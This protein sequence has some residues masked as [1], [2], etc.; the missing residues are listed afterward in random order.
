M[1]VAQDPRAEL[2]RAAPSGI[3]LFIDNVGGETLDIALEKLKPKGEVLAIGNL[4]IVNPSKS[5]KNGDKV[6]ASA[7]ADVRPYALKNWTLVITKAL[8]V[9]G[10]TAFHH[11]DKFPR[12]WKDIGPLVAG[13]E[14]PKQ[15]ETVIKGLES[16]P[17]A[18]E[19]YMNGVYH[20]KVIIQIAS[21]DEE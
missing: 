5:N 10:F 21:L 3:D 4:A 9:Y 12:L 7:E 13:G 17:K 15:K 6:E 11:S 2:D 14:F 1:A 19:E 20:G 8:R 18:F 16:A